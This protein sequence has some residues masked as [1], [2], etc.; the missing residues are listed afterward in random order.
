MEEL[1]ISHEKFDLMNKSMKNMRKLLRDK[2]EYSKDKV[3]LPMPSSSSDRLSLDNVDKLYVLLS[4]SFEEISY[5][6]ADIGF[7]Q[8]SE[9]I[10]AA[11]DGFRHIYDMMADYTLSASEY[12]E[13]MKTRKYRIAE[14]T[15]STDILCRP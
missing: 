3:Y 9:A 7:R 4:L 13:E 15:I 10:E 5:R 6:L 14:A 12:C 8:A 11:V 2:I 1:Q